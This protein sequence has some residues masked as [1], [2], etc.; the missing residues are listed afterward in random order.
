M[1]PHGEVRA[2]LAVAAHALHLEQGAATWEQIAVRAQVGFAVARYTVRNMR[3][4]GDLA[5]VGAEKPAGSDRWRRLYEPSVREINDPVMN[6]AQA[7]NMWARTRAEL[8]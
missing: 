8:A 1:R 5:D 3:R 4:C 7:V 6:L 2:A